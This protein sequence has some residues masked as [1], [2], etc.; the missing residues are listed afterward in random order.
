MRWLRGES[1]PQIADV[2]AS[3]GGDPR[4]LAAF[5]LWHS[6]SGLDPLLALL[7]LV[8]RSGWWADAAESSAFEDRA[9]NSMPI[10][11]PRGARDDDGFERQEMK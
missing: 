3:T 11:R 8:F 4:A 5:L 1:T 7:D 10:P 2:G 9:T 6:R